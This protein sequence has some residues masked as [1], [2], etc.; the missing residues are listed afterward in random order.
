LLIIVDGLWEGAADCFVWHIMDSELMFKILLT[1]QQNSLQN[2]PDGMLYIEYDK[3][4]QGM[5]VCHST[6]SIVS[7]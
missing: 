2:V 1:C 4:R 3:E 6:V 5:D 7:N